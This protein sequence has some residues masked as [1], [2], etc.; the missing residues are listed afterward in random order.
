MIKLLQKNSFPLILALS[1]F[2][3]SFSFLN[4]DGS[5]LI[6]TLVF[7]LS[8]IAYSFLFL[9]NKY[10]QKTLVSN[11]D[12][13][14]ILFFVFFFDLSMLNSQ[15]LNEGLKDSIFIHSILVI[16]LGLKSTY[17][18]KKHL[19]Q[20]TF[21]ANLIL[22]IS[23]LSA[24]AFYVFLPFDR[25]VSFFMNLQRTF[26]AF[27]NAFALLIVS[28][29]PFLLFE[30]IKSKKNN[31]INYLNLTLT[32]SAFILT[33]SRG[34]Y[35]VLGIQIILFFFIFKKYFTKKKL[36]PILTIIIATFLTC[37]A[38]NN[39]RTEQ[40]I[41]VQD[42]LTLQ[43]QEGGSSISERFDFF[44]GALQLIPNNP[45][46]GSGPES[47]IYVYPSVQKEFLTNAA[48]PH[49]IFLKIAVENGLI[50]MSLFTLLLIILFS[51]SYK[52]IKSPFL[53]K[54]EKQFLKI[55]L[56]SLIGIILHNL[57][58]YNL[59]FVVNSMIFA[60][61]LGL[62]ASLS[63]YRR[64]EG[65]SSKIYKAL[66]L[67]VTLVLF[68]VTAYETVNLNHLRKARQQVDQGN[69][70]AAIPYYQAAKSTL[71]KRDLAIN[72]SL[73]SKEQLLQGL[74]PDINGFKAL[75]DHI[76]VFNSIDAN[77]WNLSAKYRLENPEKYKFG[78]AIAYVH[79]LKAYKLNSLNELEYHDTLL[80]IALFSG[81]QDKIKPEF[82]TQI[83][84]EYLDLLKRNAHHTILTGN[85]FSAISIMDSLSYIDP[86]NKEKYQSLKYELAKTWYEETK[87]FEEKYRL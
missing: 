31:L 37:F 29:I 58:D 23:S 3:I 84:E 50:T 71:F 63:T 70:I 48:H 62:I 81:N 61:I 22:F 2:V 28:L 53:I 51:N 32:L 66:F 11:L 75:E 34:A 1:F 25:A 54:K 49:N 38:A 52:S 7:G 73:A 65:K 78:T 36:L 10:K 30:T 13:L 16:Y 83:V 60:L 4:R 68:S 41:Q 18:K 8:A 17:L 55:L 27:P 86:E 9:F 35:I 72:Y 33:Y 64:S 19:K 69:Q 45:I 12:V 76:R 87:K 26:I 59:N 74:E 6:P 43:G 39:L 24:L 77:A 20:F 42:R 40:N 47:F 15:S 44:E 82:L 85:A 80:Q 79:A 56:I 5:S 67:L 14:C 46:L 21:F 57:I